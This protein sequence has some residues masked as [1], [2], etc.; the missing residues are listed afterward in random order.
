M[1]TQQEAEA[2]RSDEP[3]CEKLAGRT[4]R[5]GTP[6]Q[7]TSLTRFKRKTLLAIYLYKLAHE[8]CSEEQ[9]EYVAYFQ[10]KLNLGEVQS[11]LQFTHTL[12]TNPRARARVKVESVLVP[13][14]GP[15]P[16]RREQRRIG[17]GYRDKGSRRDPHKPVLP[18]ELTLGWEAK[19][20]F[21]FS[22]DPWFLREGARLVAD[23]VM[24]EW[25]K[26]PTGQPTLPAAAFL[27]RPWTSGLEEA[28]LAAPST[29]E[30]FGLKKWGD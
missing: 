29:S 4:A 16:R 11:A 3:T 23:E 21:A 6:S 30:V 2:R 28:A 15:R 19:S 13:T 14:L 1:T 10:A 8:T 17:V 24:L 12:T 5:P 9:R 18:G 25:S 20:L 27:K 22:P 26:K 7:I